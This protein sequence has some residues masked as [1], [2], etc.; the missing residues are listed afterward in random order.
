MSCGNALAAVCPACG[1]VNPP[2]AKFCMSC[3]TALAGDAPPVPAPAPPPAAVELPPEERRQV[4]VVFAD[5]SGYTAIAERMDP[6]EVKSFV[7]GALRR[8]G[9]EVERFGGSVD[10][11]IGDNVMAVFGAPI[12]HEDDAERA[13][14]AALGM[15]DAMAEINERFGTAQSVSLA[16]RVGVNTGEVVAG[17]MGDGY[18]VIGDTVNVAARL[19]TASQPGSV[20]VGERTFR[21]TREAIDYRRLEPLTLKGKAEP[22]PAW[23]AAGVIAAQPVRRSSAQTPLVGRTDKLDVLRSVYERVE[24]GRRPHLV[25]VIGQAGVGK[26][27]L[28]HELERWLC[29]RHPPPTFREGRC[30]P[31]GS[32][33]VYWPLAEVIRA[34]AEIVDGDSTEEAWEKLLAAME[35][36]MAY[37]GEHSE[38]A[39]RRAAT[40]GRLL[41]IEAPRELSPA[42]AEDPQRMREFFFSAVRSVIEAMARR[43]PL[44]LVLEDIHWADHGMLDLVE[45][46]AQWV[47]APLMILCL[48]RDELLERR[49]GWGGGRHDATSILLEPLTI[50]QTVELLEALLPGASGNG[51]VKVIAERAGGNP[52][53]AEEMAR[54]IA[55]ESSGGLVDMP[56]TVQS[57]LA[58]RLDSLEPLERRLVQHAAVV[59][60]TFWE[61]ALA[62]AVPDDGQLRQALLD[63]QEK[64][65]IIPDDTMRIAGEREYAFKHVLIRD[66]AYGMLPKSVRWRKHYEIGRFI[67]DRAGERTDEVV[68]LLAE[69]YGRA[70]TLSDEAG[71]E[72]DE[73]EPIHQKALHFLEAAGD[74]A[75]ALYSNPEAYEHYEAVRRIECPHDPATMARVIEKQ[76]DVAFRMGRV[77]AAVELW[78]ECL[79]YHR[80][81]EDLTRVADLHRKIGAGLW[82]MG[83][84]KLAIERYQKGINLLKDGPACLEL[85]H[86]YEEAASLYMHAGDNMLAIYASEK[87]LRLAEKLQETRV[88]SRAHGIFG[89]VFGRIGDTAKARENLER[90]VELARD[91]DDGETIR[92]LLTLGHHLEVSEADYAGASQAYGE[93]LALAQQIGD[94]PAQVELQ[95]SIAQVASY[96]ADWDAVEVA[97]EA[98][99]DLAERE[100]LVGKLCYPCVLR[101][102]LAWREGRWD[103]AER[104]CR[105]AHELAEQ[106]G[107][108]EVSFA[109]LYWLGRALRDRGDH[110]AAVSELDRALDVCERAGLIAQSIE[111]MSA[112][113]ITLKISGKN[114]QAREAA[115]EAGHLAE[116]LHYPVGE[117]AALEA[118]ATTVGD[119]EECRRKMQEARDLWQG[120]GRPLDV[121][122]CDLL[123]GHL[124]A[125]AEE[126]DADALLDKAASEFERLGVDHLARW[127]RALV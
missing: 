40:I 116:R 49:S 120:L 31:Y 35:G 59:G 97:A 12:A 72:H 15:Q 20:T 51:A 24:K 45:Y 126:P 125:H 117:A 44:V 5:L 25:T 63:L 99:A 22:V 18:T 47:R 113:A 39:E 21:A 103:D 30:L 76:G 37:A 118:L 80:S 54:R 78:E 27:R 19:Q 52:F 96:R 112:R 34:E 84:R 48:A 124:L 100:G 56:D 81:Q 89:R 71:I 127:A 8:L 92:A 119:T 16:L 75:A 53:F 1:T 86:L 58:A 28:R 77:G 9:Q 93:A 62:V 43:N 88:A 26:S 108:S 83:E 7:D 73:I 82:H 105:R 95:S 115:E 85:V 87:A 29:E 36:L 50:N 11:Y 122:I 46:L 66:V 123:L 69:H 101:G 41:G 65:I 79:E 2:E 70:A 60:R 14:R 13:V 61:G 32:G 90:S 111:A 121:A 68:P 6:E 57:L 42:D 107:W 106:V 55:D 98:S 114:D 109:A 23:E 17:A 33:I 74:T 10:K 91:S 110:A 64:D 104:W 3:G 4:T 67:E 94:L 38:P 102:V